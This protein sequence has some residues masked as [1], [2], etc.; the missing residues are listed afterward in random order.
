MIVT[1]MEDAKY[2]ASEKSRIV[3]GV[4]HWY[5]RFFAHSVDGITQCV[6]HELDHEPTADDFSSLEAAWFDRMKK[7]KTLNAQAYAKSDDVRGFVVNGIR[8]AWLNSEQRV[9]IRQSVADKA[10]AGRDK[11][12]LYLSDGAH[13]VTPEKATEV[14]AALEVYASDCNDTVMRHEAAIAA[15]KTL[16]EVYAYDETAG[17]PGM[18]EFEL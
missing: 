18:P 4:Q 9:S 13:E 3:E 7:C 6:E 11:T 14:L 2:K 12:V 15:L 8:V 16:D 1:S 10:A 17:F 5:A